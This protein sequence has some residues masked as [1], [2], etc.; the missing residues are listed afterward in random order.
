MALQL[1]KEKIPLPEILSRLYKTKVNVLARLR[2]NT[3]AEER[4][5]Y[6][7]GRGHFG[8]ARVF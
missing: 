3:E 5:H 6:K 2:G 4:P 1:K 8:E 7:N